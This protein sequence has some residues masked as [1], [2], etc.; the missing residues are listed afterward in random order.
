MSI[1]HIEAKGAQYAPPDTMINLSSIRPDTETWPGAVRRGG[2]MRQAAVAS[3][4]IL[5]VCRA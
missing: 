1:D 4:G 3:S 5:P 2:A